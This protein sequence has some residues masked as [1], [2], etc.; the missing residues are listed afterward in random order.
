MSD[1]SQHYG[2]RE[3]LFVGVLRRLKVYFVQPGI[4]GL[5]LYKAPNSENRILNRIR[6][7]KLRKF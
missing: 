4:F 5:S 7:A 2:A 1:S 6:E 3:G